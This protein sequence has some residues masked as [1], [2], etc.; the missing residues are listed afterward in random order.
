M[1]SPNFTEPNPG[2]KKLAKPLKSFDLE[3]Q[4]FIEDINA[5]ELVIRECA[6]AATMGRVKSKYGSESVSHR[7]KY[8]LTHIFRH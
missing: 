1:L 2:L 5:K 6:G 7:V 4:P 8:H 3:F